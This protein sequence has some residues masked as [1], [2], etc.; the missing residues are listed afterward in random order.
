M[1]GISHRKN[2]TKCTLKP[3]EEVTH[4]SNLG[5]VREPFFVA[6]YQPNCFYIEILLHMKKSAVRELFLVHE[7]FFWFLIQVRTSISSR[8]RDFVTARVTRV[9]RSPA[10][11]CHVHAHIVTGHPK[12]QTFFDCENKAFGEYKKFLGRENIISICNPADRDHACDTICP[13][14]LSNAP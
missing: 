10:M 9:M 11:C 14:Q 6:R 3:N 1:A 2:I 8:L 13:F 7:N 12:R 5:S 4:L